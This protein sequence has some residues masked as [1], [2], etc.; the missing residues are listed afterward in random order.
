MIQPE[1]EPRCCGCCP[2][3][4]VVIFFC[5]FEIVSGILGLTSI[6][7][8]SGE[9]IFILSYIMLFASAASGLYGA[10]KYRRTFISIY[11]YIRLVYT[12][13]AFVAIIMMLAIASLFCSAVRDNDNTRDATS[14]CESIVLTVAIILLIIY[15]PLIVWYLYIIKRFENYLR[16][17]EQGVHYQQLAAPGAVL[18]DQYGRPVYAAPPYGQPAYLA[19]PHAGYAA[20]PAPQGGGYAQPAMYPGV[21]VS[22][23]TIAAPPSSSAAPS[24]P[25]AYDPYSSIPSETK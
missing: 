14:T 11:F 21:P 23:A 10:I 5:I 3:R 18:V 6:S 20:P 4:T 13:L 25:P 12:I 22:A 15:A 7:A 16:S 19:Q 17:R 2:L 9:A 1:E 24:A 8:S